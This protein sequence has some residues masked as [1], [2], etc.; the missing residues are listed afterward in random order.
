MQAS[1]S[2]RSSETLIV[3]ILYFTEVKRSF[4]VLLDGWETYSLRAEDVH[5]LGVCDHPR[6]CSMARN[7][8]IDR[9]NYA[10]VRNGVLG[11]ENVS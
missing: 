2:L 10:N 3:P 7:G 8:W 6:L 9:V 1:S 4:S 11:S 5:C